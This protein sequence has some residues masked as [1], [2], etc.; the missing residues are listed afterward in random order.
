M[1][2]TPDYDKLGRIS[3][4]E[5]TAV[6]PG[7]GMVEWEELLAVASIGFAN[8]VAD[9]LGQVETGPLSSIPQTDGFTEAVLEV[10]RIQLNNAI[11]SRRVG[12]IKMRPA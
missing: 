9:Y 8:V 11:V 10:F 2:V 12:K 1:D 3:Q 5:I 7:G 4:A 6:K